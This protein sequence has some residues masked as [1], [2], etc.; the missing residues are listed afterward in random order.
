MPST[1]AKTR[2]PRDPFLDLVRAGAILLVVAQHWLMP[3]LSF[4]NGQLSTGNALTTP[5]WWLLTWV[6]QVMPMVFF[7]GGAANLI[8]FRAHRSRGGSTRDW[9]GNRLHRL[10][11]PVL[12]LA[13][14]WVPLPHLLADL[15]VPA[16]PLDI[17]G[18]IVAQLLWFLV[19]Y[20]GTV[21][22]T[23]IAVRTHERFGLGAL[24]VLTIAALG[25][26]WL[27]FDGVPLVGYLNAVFVWFAVHQ[28][29]FHYVDGAL[30]AASRLRGACL[31]VAGFGVTALL[32]LAGPYPA[33]MVGMPGAPVSNMS[34]PSACLLAVACGQLGL[35]LWLRPALLRLAAKRPVAGALRWL[36]TRCMTVYLWHM[37]A[38]V[39]VTGIAV[40]GFG[41]A[42]PEPGSVPWFAVAPVWLGLLAVTLAGLLRLFGRFE[43]SAGVPRALPALAQLVAGGLLTA[44]GLL[45]LAA[46]GFGPPSEAGVPA[47]LTSGPV[48]WVAL[49]LAGFAM[50]SYRFSPR[51]TLDVTA[52]RGI[53]LFAR[54]LPRG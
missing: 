37:P 23:P 39:A 51:T 35:L 25:V 17:A 6:S 38:L 8:S 50:I 4:H 24:A 53:R 26:D 20:L 1:Q 36:G 18:G 52:D 28:L 10:L 33:S 27:R 47:V 46:N 49:V 30:S 31:A 42:T 48:P 45:G 41:Y 3:V 16:Q 34:P 21:L 19:V 29:G 11:V 2:R 13:A 15:G 22:I 43:A 9:L 32:V 54:L 14:V 44:G 7:A 5:G 12:A 40:L